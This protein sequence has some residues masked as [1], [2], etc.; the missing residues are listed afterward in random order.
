MTSFVRSTLA[1]FALLLVTAPAA[2]ASAPAMRFSILPQPGGSLSEGGDYFVVELRPGIATSEALELSNPTRRPVTVL[3]AA[4]DAS[5]AQLGGVDYSPSEA[6]PNQA[7]AWIELQRESV[8]I[9]PGAVK[10]IPFEIVVPEDAPPGINLAGI[11]A[12][13]PAPESARDESEGMDTSVAVQTRRV[14]AVQ[15]ELPGP[16]DPLLKVEGVSAVARPDGIYLQLDIRNDGHGFAEGE[17]TIELEENRFLRTFSL[18]KVV[19]GTTVGYPIRWRD[20]AP[21]DGSYPA[22]VKIDYT[23]GEAAWSGEVVVGDALRGELADRDIGSK[24]RFPIVALA[25]GAGVVA[26]TVAAFGI[27]RRTRRRSA[28]PAPRR[29][30]AAGGRTPGAGG[31]AEQVATLMRSHGAPPPPPP[32]PP[33]SPGPLPPPSIGGR[34]PR[35]APRG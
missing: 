25:G 17:G 8:E 13:M 28:A 6:P 10:V 31:P 11:A 14:I 22:S 24:D 4:V 33:A 1:I 23:S 21:D 9:A 18:D 12:W 30:H 2:A 29:D 7:G 3:L 19:P 27:R 20:A 32:P 16:Q 35:D 5:T 34:L 26:A 15:V